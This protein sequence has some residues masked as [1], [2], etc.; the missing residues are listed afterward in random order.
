[1][2]YSVWDRV[3]FKITKILLP[4]ASRRVIFDRRRRRISSL[5]GIIALSLLIKL[6]MWQGRRDAKRIFR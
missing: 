2:Q 6:A 3:V 4:V 5:K 1:M